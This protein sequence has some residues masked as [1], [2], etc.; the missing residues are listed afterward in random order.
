MKNQLNL[1]RTIFYQKRLFFSKRISDLQTFQ[2]IL[3]ETAIPLVL[4]LNHPSLLKKGHAYKL[5]LDIHHR[6]HKKSELPNTTFS[7]ENKQKCEKDEIIKQSIENK[8]FE[9]EEVKKASEKWIFLHYEPEKTEE[10]YKVFNVNKLPCFFLFKFGRIIDCKFK[11]YRRRR[12]N[13]QHQQVYQF[14]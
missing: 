12:W 4:F 14:T 3:S 7:I 5:L 10:M 13:G 6:D 9:L 11:S 8:N 2:E 1:F